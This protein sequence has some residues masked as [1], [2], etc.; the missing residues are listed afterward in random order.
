MSVFRAVRSRT[1]PILQR[2]LM[3]VRCRLLYR[4]DIEVILNRYRAAQILQY[5]LADILLFARC[6]H[7]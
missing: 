7:I 3:L 5:V 4:P 2:L 1:A 6:W